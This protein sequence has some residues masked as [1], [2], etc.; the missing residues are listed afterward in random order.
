MRNMWKKVR[1]AAGEK[2]FAFLVGVAEVSLW[3]DVKAT[4]AR[5]YRRSLKGAIN[6]MLR[7]SGKA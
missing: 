1:D 6:R 7:R 5:R 3:F 4:S 2:W